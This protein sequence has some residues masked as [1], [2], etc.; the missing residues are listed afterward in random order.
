AANRENAVDTGIPRENVF[1]MDNGEV[2]ELGEKTF[3]TTGKTVDAFMVMVDGLGVGDVGEVVLRD[4][5]ILSAEGMIVIIATL[6]KEKGHL[7]KN[8]D[9]IS[10]GFIYLKENQEILDQIRARL[11]NIINQIPKQQQIEAE[12]LKSVIRDQIGQFLYQKTKR[13][14]MI[15]PV[16]IEV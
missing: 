12:Y 16:V 13:R 8:P 2:A 11:R 9:I 10:R 5:I 14:P 7:L 4:R 1:L 15:L 6:D 3:E